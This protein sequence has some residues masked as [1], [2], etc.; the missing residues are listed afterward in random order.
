MSGPIRIAEL[1]V[2]AFNTPSMDPPATIP[3]STLEALLDIAEAAH[4]YLAAET[5]LW[6]RSTFDATAGD[7]LRDALARI[8]FT[9]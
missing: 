1:R 7:R 3:A 5:A 4:A 6:S 8:D 2:E 9:P